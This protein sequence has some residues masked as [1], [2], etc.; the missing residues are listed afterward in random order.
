MEKIT[1]SVHI[2]SDNITCALSETQISLRLRA[3]ISLRCTLP[4]ALGRHL[5]DCADAQRI[6][7]FAGPTCIFCRKCCAPVQFIL[8]LF[9]LLLSMRS[10]AQRKNFKAN[11]TQL[12]GSRQAKKCLLTCAVY[13]FGSSCACAKYHPG[14]GSPFIHF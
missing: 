12:F 10:L 9:S 13:I 7:V 5:S 3:D 4:S 2:N 11:K 8:I 1:G 6:R 14:L